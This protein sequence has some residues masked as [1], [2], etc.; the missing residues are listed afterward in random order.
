MVMRLKGRDI[1]KAGGHVVAKEAC[2]V[3]DEIDLQ[4]VVRTYHH[5]SLKV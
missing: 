3:M 5:C 1:D 2:R 4:L